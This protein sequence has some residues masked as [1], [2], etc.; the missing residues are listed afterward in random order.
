MHAHFCHILASETS[1]EYTKNNFIL[2]IS[3]N[4]RSTP[5]LLLKLK[6]IYSP[7]CA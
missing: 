4:F 2:V 6:K 7:I 1:K 3:L 5:N